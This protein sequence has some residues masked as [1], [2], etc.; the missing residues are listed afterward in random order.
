[1]T[2]S[3]KKLHAPANRERNVKK[4]RITDLPDSDHLKACYLNVRS[5]RN[6]FLDLEELTA[7]EKFDII[8]ITESRLNTKDKDFLA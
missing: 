3:N 6:K 5:T 4:H 7:T 2:L 8:A 1:M